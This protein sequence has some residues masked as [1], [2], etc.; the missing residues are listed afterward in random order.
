MNV[1][2]DPAAKLG[3]FPLRE[4]ESYHCVKVLRQK[5]GDQILLSD[6]N[7]HI[8]KAEV[9]G[10]NKKNQCAV[11]AYEIL[12][13]E[14]MRHGKLHIAIAPTKSID[15]F[16][17]FLEKATECGIEE[18][19]PLLCMNS[20]RARIKPERLEKIMVAA[21]KQSMRAWLPK[22]NPIIKFDKFVE[23]INA[24]NKF[25][26]HCVEGEKLFLNR[27][28]APQKDVLILIGPEGDFNDKEISIALGNNFKPLSLG[29]YRLRTETA[30]LLACVE[31]NL[32]NRNTN[33]NI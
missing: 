9:A 13:K 16:E 24:E 2:Y 30:A 12:R 3:V 18:I 1:Y 8:Y 6:G 23:S 28:V 15:R 22:L 7:G 26:A 14:E 33:N 10:V 32:L 27:E 20:E 19:T 4:E 31:F 11:E 17:W 21:M 29:E 25:I 5:V